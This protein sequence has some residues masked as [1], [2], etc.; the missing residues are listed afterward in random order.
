MDWH[1]IQDE[2]P[3]PLAVVLVTQPGG[4]PDSWPCRVAIMYEDE[5][6]QDEEARWIK[7]SHWTT[8]PDLPDNIK[9]L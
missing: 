4:Y 5:S 3:P 6:W 7:P 8:V 9:I 1:S 2:L